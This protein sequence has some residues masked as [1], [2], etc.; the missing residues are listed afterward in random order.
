MKRFQ[1]FYI[2]YF[3][4]MAGYI[5]LV[6][7]SPGSV[8]SDP[9]MVGAPDGFYRPLVGGDEVMW[10]YFSGILL[11]TPFSEIFN[12]SLFQ[13][14]LG[15]VSIGSTLS[16]SSLYVL[17]LGI[18]KYFLIHPYLVILVKGL[19]SFAIILS[20][21]SFS[22]K[23]YNQL[24][25]PLLKYLAIT[26]FLILLNPLFYWWA[27]SY[28]RDDLILSVSSVLLFLFCLHKI[29]LISKIR[30][31]SLL[32]ICFF[33]FL[34]F[35]LYLIVF[36]L[37]LFISS[38]IRI[39]KPLKPSK[40]SIL[41]VI[42][43]LTAFSFLY[44]YAINFLI[45]DKFKIYDIFFSY[46]KPLPLNVITIAMGEADPI[47]YMYIVNFFIVLV[48]F[49]G[50][51]YQSIANH[52]PTI[53]RLKFLLPIVVIELIYRG[54]LISFFGDINGVRQCFALLPFELFA[55]QVLLLP[56]T[57]LNRFIYSYK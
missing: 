51:L 33:V 43:A 3:I 31:R 4:I 30:Y 9:E 46:L 54:I 18:L 48:F 20:L 6:Q 5:L 38:Y 2:S 35:R 24:K 1:V 17:Y 23:L 47:K 7:G 10:D 41:I 57:S 21:S 26:Y 42:P 11:Q 15:Y 27:F 55:F 22:L 52:S 16:S 50:L 40:S 14:A 37:I 19:I 29:G 36:P 44:S 53:R 49:S 28:M 39:N 25:Y 13:I 8:T 34:N 32:I 45:L 56:R 12:L